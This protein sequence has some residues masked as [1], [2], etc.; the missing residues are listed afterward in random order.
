MRAHTSGTITF[1]LVSIPVK[2]YLAACDDQGIDFNLLS[3]KTGNRLKQKYVDAATGEEVLREDMMKGH[4]HTRGQFVTFTNEELKELELA[5]TKAINITEFVDES[6]IHALHV[7]KSYY[8]GPDKGGDKGYVL[9]SEAM[10]ERRKVAIAQWVHHGKGHLVVIRP[11][12]GGLL[13]QDLWYENEI[14]DFSQIEVMATPISDPERKLA[15]QLID[16]LTSGG[17]DPSKYSDE[18]T[19]ALLEAVQAKIAGQEITI[20]HDASPATS[21]VDLLSALKLTLE[22]AKAPKKSKKK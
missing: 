11:Y 10:A 13:L 18:Y 9:L 21:S 20:P 1:G 8:L 14:R 12:K 4:E 19:E 5:T 6:T 17:F 15:G 16:A 3:K 22:Q 2:V 7:E